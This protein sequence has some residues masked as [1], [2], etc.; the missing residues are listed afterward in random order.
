M[1]EPRQI[2]SSDRH[3][4][5]GVDNCSTFHV[6]GK[7]K[8]RMISIFNNDS[9][10]RKRACCALERGGLCDRI[11][12]LGFRQSNCNASELIIYGLFYSFSSFHLTCRFV[13]YITITTCGRIRILL[14]A[15]H[16]LKQNQRDH[17]V[18]RLCVN[19]LLVLRF[20]GLIVR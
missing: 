10:S 9:V 6:H 2:G 8:F 14:L 7:E 18:T 17:T 13:R 1:S 20:M 5:S 11:T 15:C 12:T 3:T 4:K 19:H 16:R